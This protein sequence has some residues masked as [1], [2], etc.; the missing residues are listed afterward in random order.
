MVRRSTWI[1]LLIFA[2]LVGFAIYFQRYQANKP[3]VVSTA[4]PTEP[5]TYLYSLGEAQVDGIKI[6]DNAGKNIDLYRDP[7]TSQWGIA[8]I[9]VDQVDTTKI[10]SISSQ[11][12]LIQIQDTLA[13]TVPLSTIGLEPP[14]YTITLSTSAGKQ[15]VTYVGIQTAIGSGYYV[16]DATG[17]VVIVG[18]TPMDS[19]LELVN[20]PPLLPTATPTET[21]TG[22]STPVPTSSPVTAT[23]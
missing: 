11:L 21:P 4:T 16:Q 17:Q 6:A 10:D 13:Q 2:I 22:A 19:I 1:V 14:A 5:P 23:P 12:V 7:L 3:T 9:P 18:K 15:F 8:N 20:T